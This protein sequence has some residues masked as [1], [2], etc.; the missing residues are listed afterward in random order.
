M[1]WW[2][3]GV[4]RVKFAL[5]LP[6]I[7]SFLIQQ[8]C[9]M[10]QMAGATPQQ[11]QQKAQEGLRPYFPNA[12]VQVI[13]Q[14]QGI[15][16]MTC[17][18]NIG[19]EMIVQIAQKMPEIPDVQKLKMLRQ[20][21]GLIGAGTY[22]RFIIGFE[23]EAISLEVDRNLQPFLLRLPNQQAYEQEYNQACGFSE[24]ATSQTA[25]DMH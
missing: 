25:S 19:H 16:A 11:I 21:G 12:V 3:C 13:P 15:V 23:H 17:T 9:N 4:I 8:K 5:V 22:R 14:Q 2:R 7:T 10:A 24:A 20:W 1:L 6:L 18:K